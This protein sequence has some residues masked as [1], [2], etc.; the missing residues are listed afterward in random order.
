MTMKHR[1]LLVTSWF[2]A[3]FTY[4]VASHWSQNGDKNL[5][6]VLLEALGNL[7]TPV[8]LLISAVVVS[9]IAMAKRKPMAER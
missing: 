5:L 1:G 3:L 4:N 6:F 9:G 7:T 8:E 2:A